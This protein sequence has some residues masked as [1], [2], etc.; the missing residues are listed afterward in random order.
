MFTTDRFFAKIWSAWMLVV[1]VTV[2]MIGLN[3]TFFAI[4][5]FIG[6]VAMT[7]WCIH[8][9]YRTEYFVSFAK[10]RMFFN[11]SCAPMFA[12]LLISGITFKKMKLS[13]STSLMLGL[14][15]V[16]LVLLAYA[17][18]YYCRSKNDILHYRGDRV[19]SIEPPQK[20]SWWQAGLA[21]GLSSLMYPLM[22]SHDVPAT[23]LI[24]CLMLLSVYM[25]FYNRDKISALRDLK[26]LESKENRHYIFMDIEA[27]QS[28][29]AASWLGRL[30][31]VRAR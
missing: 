27:I 15:P 8:C 7:L 29:R 11:M 5:V 25:V 4:P 14:A 18:A 19:E 2:L 23:G 3:P 22:K 17:V 31:A 16:V 12:S 13:T 1:I 9:A 26:T 21:A 24:Y 28:M 20:V 6:V 10:L 30:F